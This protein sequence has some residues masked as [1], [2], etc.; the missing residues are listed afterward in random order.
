MGGTRMSHTPWT[1][2]EAARNVA[3]HLWDGA[4]VNLGIGLPQLVSNFVP[5]GRE[6]LYHAEHG[7]LG[8]GPAATPG[9]EDPDLLDAGTNPVTLVSGAAIF[10]HDISFAM[11]RG[12]HIDVA[13][14]GAF[15]VSERGDLANWM[16]KGQKLG[17]VGGAMDLAAGAANVYVLMTHTDK[18]GRPKIVKECDYPLTANEC[19]D[20]IFTDLAVID[21]TAGGLVVREMCPGMTIEELQRVTEAPLKMRAETG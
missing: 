14:L 17:S 16:V 6:V 1:R 12:G 19:V 20:R 3:N 11:I 10:S 5:E 15:Q 8:I 21:V 18:E 4:Y 9:E 7:I 2:E 13:V